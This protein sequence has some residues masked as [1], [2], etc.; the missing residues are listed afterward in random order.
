MAATAGKV[1]QAA[2]AETNGLTGVELLLVLSTVMPGEANGFVLGNVK[3]NDGL[4]A[5]AAGC[6]GVLLGG[7]PNWKTGAAG[8]L[9]LSG[10]EPG[11]AKGAK[12]NDGLEA[13]AAGCD[14][15]V[16]GGEPN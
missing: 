14:G 7:D 11:E 13:R 15:V 3:L 12:L 2:K 16:L 8:P 4:A 1:G 6:E 9:A 10:I 5:R